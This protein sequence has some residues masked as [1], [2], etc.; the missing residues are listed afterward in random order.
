MSKNTGKSYWHC[1][2]NITKLW[3]LLTSRTATTLVLFYIISSMDF[4]FSFCFPIVLNTA[5]RKFLI[6]HK[7][8]NIHQP[9]AQNPPTVPHFSQSKSHVPDTAATTSLTSSPSFPPPCYKPGT[10][11]TRAFYSLFPFPRSLFPKSYMANPLISFMVLLKLSPQWGLS[12]SFISNISCPPIPPQNPWF[13]LPYS[14]FFLSPNTCHLLTHHIT[15]LFIMCI[16]YYRSPLARRVG[17]FVL[18]PYI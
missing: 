17:I 1:P 14:R 9:S 16:T 5:A 11:E 6:K 2:Q 18:S 7:S 12:Y 4:C 10:L 8:Y 15:N 3:P 13:P